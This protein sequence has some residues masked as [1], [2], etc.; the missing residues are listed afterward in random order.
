[1]K[2]SARA[3]GNHARL[4]IGLLYGGALACWSA[5]FLALRP[6]WLALAALLPVAL[7]LGWQVL[8]LR[9]TDPADALRRF[10]SNRFAGLLLFLACGV[11]GMTV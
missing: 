3:L 5:A 8:G 9:R 2:S 4:G 7:H 6:E 1:M 10:R 11:V